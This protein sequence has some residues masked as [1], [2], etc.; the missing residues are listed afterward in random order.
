MDTLDGVTRVAVPAATTPSVEAAPA[1]RPHRSR[2]WS[3]R[4]A[5]LAAVVA[6]VLV[7]ATR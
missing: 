7:A 3:W 1:T 5:A 6:G 4:V 2:A